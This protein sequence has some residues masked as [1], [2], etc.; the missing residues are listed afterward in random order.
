MIANHGKAKSEEK[1]KRKLLKNSEDNQHAE[2]IRPWAGI[3]KK[4][5]CALKSRPYEFCSGEGNFY[6]FA[7]S[8]RKTTET[9]G[10]LLH[11]LALFQSFCNFQCYFYV[12]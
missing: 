5:T 4:K 8:A 9:V 12:N 3:I 11:F 7:G 2:I 6:R 1:E 10:C